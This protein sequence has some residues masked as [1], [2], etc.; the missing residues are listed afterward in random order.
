MRTGRAHIAAL[1]FVILLGS[2]ASAQSFKRTGTS[3]FVFL[4]I[5]VSARYAAMGESALAGMETGA[6]G[7]FLNPASV[8]FGQERH[9]AGLSYAPWLADIAHVACAYAFRS[10]AGTFGVT[11][12]AFDY[13]SMTRTVRT[14][15]AREYTS[16]GTF[17]ATALAVGVSYARRLTDRFS[18]GLTAKYVEERIDIYKAS[19]V[20]LDGGVLY[21][22]GFHTLRIAAVVQNFGTETAFRNDVFGMPALL[23]MGAA[24]EVVGE[25]GSDLRVT[26]T[27]EAVHPSDNDERVQVGIEAAWTEAV[28]IRYGHKFLYDEEDHSFGLGVR[29]NIGVAVEA[30]FAYVL[31]GRLGDVLRFSI[32]MGL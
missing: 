21:N 6:L 9:A 14:V 10:D 25:M 11:V 4:E 20:L 18:F 16:A 15:G 19:N 13:G 12:N 28:M 31:Y 3:G 5:P 8:P 22:T 26:A 17:D 24:M 27:A 32:Q 23:R 2:A 7:L 30:D 29:T 1:A